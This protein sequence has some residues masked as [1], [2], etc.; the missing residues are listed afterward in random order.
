MIAYVSAS[1]VSC[2]KSFPLKKV[3][4]GF[5]VTNRTN[6]Y[7]YSFD[8][9]LLFQKKIPTPLIEMHLITSNHIVYA[10]ETSKILTICNIYT[11]DEIDRLL[12]PFEQPII[13]VFCNLDKNA[14]YNLSSFKA[15]DIMLC[16]LLA[17]MDLHV[18]R[19]RRSDD[20]A[21]KFS[22]AVNNLKFSD[23]TSNEISFVKLFI[24]PYGGIGHLNSLKFFR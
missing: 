10:Q 9:T 2:M 13:N 18:F 4:G 24:L 22:L 5:L 11:G 16:I 23:K 21:F 17:S 19:V 7:S 12:V 8:S 1:D 20:D 3:P 14:T 15:Y 6:L